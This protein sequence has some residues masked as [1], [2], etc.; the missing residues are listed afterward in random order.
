[1]FESSHSVL[2]PEQ[3]LIVEV[4]GDEADLLWRRHIATTPA[5]PVIVMEGDQPEETPDEAPAVQIHWGEEK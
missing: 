3:G 1:M 4:D 2:F 5:E